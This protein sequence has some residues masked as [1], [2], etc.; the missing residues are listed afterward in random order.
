MKLAVKQI[1][2]KGHHKTVQRKISLLKLNHIDLCEFGEILTPGENKYIITF[3]NDF[4]KFA[5]VYLLKKKSDALESLKI[6]PLKWK[7]SLGTRSRE[8]KVIDVENMNP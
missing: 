8:L 2:S 7:I 1:S 5:Y 3:I 6:F 4:F